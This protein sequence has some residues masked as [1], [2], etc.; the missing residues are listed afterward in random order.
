[1]FIYSSAADYSVTDW[2]KSGDINSH[3]LDHVKV[4]AS[5]DTRQA[6]V[7]VRCASGYQFG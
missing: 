5:T 2:Q 3:P 7:P 6:Q 4:Y 1:M